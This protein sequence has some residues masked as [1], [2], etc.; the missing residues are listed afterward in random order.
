MKNTVIQLPL[1]MYKVVKII[2]LKLK[3]GKR[4]GG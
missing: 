4:K 2:T 1:K 3:A